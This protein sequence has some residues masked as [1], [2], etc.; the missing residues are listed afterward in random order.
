VGWMVSFIY[1]ACAALRLARFNTQVETADKRYFTGL[2]SPTAAGVAA[3]LVWVG[4]DRGFVGPDYAIVVAVITLLISVAMVS[5]IRYTSFKEVDFKGR[6]PFVALLL[7]VVIFAVVFV[8]PPVMLF[9][10]S[11]GYAVS[12]PIM[13]FWNRA[14][15]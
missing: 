12:G 8:D 14:R 4:F 13:S 6:V 2:P 5:N 15:G 10:A 3:S 7:V 1:V 11:F 9:V